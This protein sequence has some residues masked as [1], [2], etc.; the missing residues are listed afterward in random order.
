M[1]APGRRASARRRGHRSPRI[2]RA[3]EFERI[4]GC[5]HRAIV[6]GWERSSDLAVACRP[7]LSARRTCLAARVFRCPARARRCSARGPAL[8]ADM[9]FLD[10]E[11]SVA[12]LEKEAASQKRKPS[13]R[14]GSRTGATRCSACASTRGTRP[15]PRTTSSGGGRLSTGE[16]LERDHAPQGA[17]GRRG[18]HGPP[19]LTQV[20][21]EAERLA[22]RSHRHRGPDRDGAGPHQRQGDLRG[23]SPARDDHPRPGRHVGFDGDARP[24]GPGSGF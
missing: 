10:L 22:E 7:C 12:P 13:P 3:S 6:A 8:G 15:G 14:S 23:Q 4:G 19:L 21:Q 20:E 16:R 17:G 11:D 24:A 9:V 1:T 2:R 5:G 18:R